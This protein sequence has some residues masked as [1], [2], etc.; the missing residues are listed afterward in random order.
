MKI[1]KKHTSIAQLHREDGGAL[2]EACLTLPLLFML[3]LGAAEFS[4]VAYTSLEVVSA[5]K[6]GVAYGAQSYGLSSDTDGITL[7]ATTDAANIPNLTVAT[8]T[9]SFVCSDGT[10]STGANT[11][12]STSHIIQTLTVQTSAQLSPLIHVPGTP[13]TYTITGSASQVCLQ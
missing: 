11:D 10:A 13:S 3:I 2:V 12:C 7:A 6:A 5:A 1:W 9:S 8:P 4:R